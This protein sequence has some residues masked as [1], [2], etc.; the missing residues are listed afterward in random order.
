MARWQTGARERLQRAAIELLAER[1]YDRTTVAEIA[2]HAELTERTFYNYFAD[3]R[4]VLFAGQDE[5]VAV[6][7][8]EMRTQPLGLP[9]LAVVAAGLV[10]TSGWFTPR[11]EQ[12]RL[13]QQVIDAHPELQERE[14]TKIAALSAAIART[15]RD[16]GTPN[17][18]A[19]LVA[20]AGVA[21][22]QIAFTHWVADPDAGSL[23]LRIASAVD[24]LRALIGK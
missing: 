7:V 18:D 17:A 14:L 11:E 13:R 8:E 19:A 3:K 23:G 22:F 6:I 21:A 1:G 9:P 12:A 20:A 4:E 2:G 16:R 24:N 10:A 5:F 15:L